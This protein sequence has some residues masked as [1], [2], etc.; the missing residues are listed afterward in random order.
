MYE[1]MVTHRRG[2]RV[3]VTKEQVERAFH[4][5]EK[6]VEHKQKQQ[7]NGVKQIQRFSNRSRLEV[8]IQGYLGE[9]ALHNMLYE[10]DVS[11][12][13]RILVHW[14]K[15]YLQDGQL[16]DGSTIDV[17]TSMKSKSSKNFNKVSF[18]RLFVIDYKKYN[19]ATWYVLM[20]IDHEWGSP[21]ENNREYWFTFCGAY[22]GKELFVKEH[23]HQ[24][25]NSSG[26]AVSELD[27]R[28]LGYVIQIHT[29]EEKQK[30][31]NA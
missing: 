5:T 25:N 19:P 17:K 14:S 29:D 9:L 6:H 3:L 23:E 10:K 31:I 18:A 2:E 7:D 13:P 16:P 4:V 30:F 11:H 1:F 8:S 20:E 22:P 15:D 12:E 24:V 26:Y 21:I 27:L 28:D